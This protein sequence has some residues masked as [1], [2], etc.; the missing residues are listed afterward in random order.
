MIKAH[1]LKSIMC[2][3]VFVLLLNQVCLCW[4]CS[5]IAAGRLATT[6]G[7]VIVTHSNDG[8]GDVAG[9]IHVVYETVNE[10][11]TTRSVS[12]GEIPQVPI[13]YQYLTEGYAISNIHQ[14]VLGESTCTAIY[15]GNASLAMLNIVDLG[16]LALERAATAREAV[17]VM[18]NLAYEY[19]Y[20][21][22][23]ESL[24][25]GDPTELWVFHILPDET[26]KK[27]IW[28]AQRIPDD[29]V[30]TVM[31]AFIIRDVELESV[32]FMYSE[33]IKQYAAPGS[34]AIDFTAIFSGP[35]EVKCK[36]SSGR[37][38]WVVYDSVA[39]SLGVSP[40]YADLVESQPYPVSTKPDSLVDV[41][42][43]TSL[44]RVYYRGTQFDMSVLPELSGGA[45]LTPSR[46][47]TDA[48]VNSETVCWERPIATFRSI[49][50]FVGQMRNMKSNG[51]IWFAPHSSLTSQYAPFLTNMNEL[52]VGYTDNRLD[53]LGRN[54][55]AY[56]AFKYLHNVMQI[57]SYD[58]LIDIE[59]LQRE[60]EASNMAVLETVD[61]LDHAEEAQE[62]LIRNAQNLVSR[63]WTFSDTMVMKYSDG[64]CN[65][66]CSPDQPYELGYRQEWL[67]KILS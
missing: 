30:S 20:Y 55:S 18:G 65:F 5:T 37:R 9:N 16:Q 61:C 56:W 8:N 64:Y 2:M 33:N 59:T 41:S 3:L 27:A 22:A 7:S 1:P 4:S 67:H 29:H 48:T 52:P 25:V 17:E 51:V 6:D 32:D 23:G 19:G 54:E 62:V 45:F 15:Q 53:T 24:F 60:T 57:R 47:V 58:I 26:G 10:P 35:N 66:D 21:D 38:M 63:F 43:I 40:Y 44:M 42:K 14:V 11:N 34:S 36:Y 46:W 50:S 13:T 28:A 31:N 49:V 39:P 12:A